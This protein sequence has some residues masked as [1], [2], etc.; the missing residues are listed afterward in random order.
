MTTPINRRIRLLQTLGRLL[1]QVRGA[2]RLAD[3][4]VWF[5]RRTSGGTLLTNVLGCEMQLDPAQFV[6]AYLLLTPQLYDYRE[7]GL[8]RSHLQNGDTFLDV[9]AY[10][11]LYSLVASR[12]MPNG[13]VLAFEADPRTARR[14]EDHAHLNNATNITVVP[15]GVSDR[16]ERL[17]LG[18]IE[19][20]RGSNSFLLS[21]RREQLSVDCYPLTHLLTQHKVTSIRAAKFDIE[22]FGVRVLREF[23]K[24]WPARWHPN[25]LIVEQE[26]GQ[27][28]LLTDHGYRLVLRTGLNEVYIRNVAAQDTS[29]RLPEDTDRVAH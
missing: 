17:S 27:E 4:L 15:C 23:L 5:G 29:S 14:C 24:N 10:L 25:L 1:P 18:V 3:I 22:G 28:A 7:L 8:L 2:G 6:D 16:F 9:G 19:T 20:N 13:R 21:D 11:G 12:C 26:S